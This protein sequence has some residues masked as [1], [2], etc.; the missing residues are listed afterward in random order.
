AEPLASTL[1]SP[2]P[3]P[4]PLGGKARIPWSR[5]LFPQ[6]DALHQVS[7]PGTRP[8]ARLRRFS[9]AFRTPSVRLGQ[10]DGV[11]EARYASGNVRRRRSGLDLDANEISA[12][13]SK[14]RRKLGRFDIERDTRHLEDLCPPRNEV[15]TALSRFD[16][17]LHVCGDPEGN[18]VGA[19]LRDRHGIV[20]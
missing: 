6:R 10:L 13:L 16:A 9:S 3:W 7:V 19:C 8:R 4:S 20:A 5:S 1:L 12:G 2:S 15:E 14:R 11:G 18:V 17:I